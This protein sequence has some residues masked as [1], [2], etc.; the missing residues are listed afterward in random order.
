M[1]WSWSIAIECQFYLAA[2]GSSTCCLDALPILDG[3]RPVPRGRRA[4]LCGSCSFSPAPLPT[5]GW[6]L[7]ASRPFACAMRTRPRLSR[8][9]GCICRISFTAK[10]IGTVLRE[11]FNRIYDKPYGRFALLLG[12]S[13]VAVEQQPALTRWMVSARRS[14]RLP[15]ALA[16]PLGDSAWV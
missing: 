4:W 3:E 1:P 7:C 8:S 5:M 14:A 11:Y 16:G 13:L 10:S 6:L 9:P 12:A 15:L 2:P